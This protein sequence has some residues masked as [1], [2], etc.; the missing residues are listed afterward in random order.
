MRAPRTRQLPMPRALRRGER[1]FR[2]P[3]ISSSTNATPA[4]GALSAADNPAA[5]PAALAARRFCFATPSIPAQVDARLLPICT[6]G[7]SRPRLCP[8]PMLTAPAKNFTNAIRGADA[9]NSFQN[10]SFTCGIPLPAASGQNENIIH[11]AISDA[12][13]ITHN[14]SNAKCQKF[15][16]AGTV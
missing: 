11:P 8:P 1:L 14:E 6:V 2:S 5:A 12:T 10:R 15:P 9:P 4:S 13:T 3:I 7:P 16:A